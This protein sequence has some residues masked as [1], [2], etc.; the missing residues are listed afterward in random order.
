[1]AQEPRVESAWTALQKPIRHVGSITSKSYP[2]SRQSEMFKDDGSRIGHI[3]W[4]RAISEL[5]NDQEF[6][7]CSKLERAR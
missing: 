2:S 7:A 1:M 6:V 5:R 4:S 3:E